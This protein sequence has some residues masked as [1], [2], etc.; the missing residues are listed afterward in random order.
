[1]DTW[2][3]IEQ[4]AKWL[5]VHPQTVYRSAR[6]AALISTASRYESPA[7]SAFRKKRRVRIRPASGPI[8]PLRASTQPPTARLLAVGKRSNRS[9]DSGIRSIA[10]F[11]GDYDGQLMDVEVDLDVRSGMVPLISPLDVDDTMYVGTDWVVRGV[12][13][14]VHEAIKDMKVAE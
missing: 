11:G 12:R 7:R 14:F 8:Q 5:Q 1:M 9:S 2:M 13:L 3:T 4:A 10:L 6:P